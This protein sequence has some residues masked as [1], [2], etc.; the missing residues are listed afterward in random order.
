MKYTKHELPKDDTLKV[1]KTYHIIYTHKGRV[2][3]ANKNW[4]FEHCEEVLTRLSATYWEI[5][6]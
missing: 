5:G 6:C 3:T 1:I 4:S 2:Y